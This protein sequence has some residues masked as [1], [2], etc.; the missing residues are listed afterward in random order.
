MLRISFEFKIK[1]VERGINPSRIFEI[2]EER[3]L[4][5]RTLKNIISRILKE[6]SP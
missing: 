1:N 4:L 2:K 5:R 6:F 3:A